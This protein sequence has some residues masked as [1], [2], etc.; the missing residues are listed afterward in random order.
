MPKADIAIVTVIPEEY[1]AVIS[2]LG[3]EGCE[4]RH[5]P[6]SAKQPNQYGWVTGEL[7][8][9][10]GRPYLVVV[11]AAISPGPT[12]M[13]NAIAAT[14]ARFRPRHVLLVG[15]AGGFPLDG[16]GRG[17]VAISSVIYDYEYGKVADEFHPRHDFTYQ[18]DGA[19]LRS[20]VTLHA[21]D[22]EW[23]DL[24]G[25][26]R[27]EAAGRPKLLPG[28]IASG[29][30]VVDNA[31]NAFFAS[32][33]ASW[34]KILAV[35][36]EGAGA[37][38]TVNTAISGG[39]QVGFLMIR[40]IS[41]MPKGGVGGEPLP[42]TGS[43]EGN[44]AERDTWKKYA[45]A[46]AANFTVHWIKRGWPVP[47]AR[48]A[49]R[50]PATKP[51]A[52]DG[53]PP[54][55]TAIARVDANAVEFDPFAT[56][57]DSSVWLGFLRSLAPGGDGSPGAS[58]G[59]SPAWG[60]VLRAITERLD[61]AA[62]PASTV[63]TELELIKTHLDRHET[64]VAE[65]KLKELESRSADRLTPLQWYQLKA[66]RSRI[67]SGRWQWEQAG[68]ELLD[69]KRH[70]PTAE[71]ARINEAL[72]YEL[73]GEREKAHELATALRAEF[74]HS[75][76]LLT[77]W[78]RT[79]PASMTFDTLAAAA[80]SSVKEDEELNLA[81]AHRAFL[82][83]RFSEAI[84]FAQRATELDPASPHAWFLLG[85][86]KHATGFNL[87]KD[88]YTPLLREAAEHYDRAV[89]L[90]QAE[91]LSGLEAAIRFNRGKV[92]HLLGD[93]RAEADYQRAV[94]LARPDQR[95]RTE[96]AGF[97]VQVGRPTDALR[98]LEAETGEPKGERLFFEAAARY[99]RNIGD[100]RLRA[101][102]LLEA[103]VAEE[104]SDRWDDAHVL[105]VQWAVEGKG[106][107]AAR[108]VITGSRLE[109][110]NPLV[111][112]T[113]SGWLS[114]SEGHK[115]VARAA[116]HKA[117]DV[118]TAAARRD[119]IFLLAQALVSVDDD[120]LALPLLERCYRPGVLNY[121]CKKLL[122][123]ARRLERHDVSSRVCR[124]LR[125]AGS[126]DPRA[127]ET[128]IGILQM[129]DPNEAL[130][131]ARDHLVRHP[132]DR[133]VA[134][135][136]SALAL[137]LDRSELIIADLS[138]LPA[139]SDLT[140]Q[141][142]GMVVG[143][144]A[145]TGQHAAAL[146]YAYDALRAHFESEFAHGQYLAYFFKLNEHC[147]DLRVGGR[148]EPG[149]AVCYREERDETD[150]WAV[151]EDG[152]KPDLARDEYAPDHPLSKALSGHSVGDTV[153]LSH[154]GLQPRSAV[155]RQAFS[156]FI[157]R[158]H[159]C[160]DRYQLRFPG[161]TA[162]QM[163][164]VGS[165][166]EFDPS[167]IIQSL[168]QR[169]QHIERLDRT[170]R[171][172]PM[173]FSMYVELAGR[174]EIDA[175]AHMASN[176]DL[177]IRCGS[178]DDREL[179]AAIDLVKRC[180][181]LVLDLTALITLARLDLLRLVGGGSRKWV[182][183]R[184]MYERVLHLHE[185]ADEDRGSAGSVVLTDG[186]E[187]ARVEITT[188][189]R[190]RRAEFLA[191]MRNAIQDRCDIQPCPQAAALDPT[192]REQLVQAIG[193][194]SLDSILLAAHP[195]AVLWTDDLVLG[196]IGRTDF[197]TSRV[198]TQAVLFVLR[199]EGTISQQEFDQA[200][201]KLVGWHYQ[202]VVLN[203]ETLI[204]AAEVAEWRMDHWPVPPVM[205]TLANTAAD[206]IMRLRIA[207]Q[208]IRLTWR[209]DAPYH[210]RQS[211]LFAVLAGLNS[212]RLVRRLHQAVPLVFSVDVL[213]ADEVRDCIAV[214]LRHPT[215]LVLP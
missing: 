12:Q 47:P 68:R 59:G 147:P 137:R 85:E 145:E 32:V 94:E 109:A 91:K 195:D 62:P 67:F 13:A 213:S 184:T 150:R 82:E 212:V 33:H 54:P 69:A 100:D 198:W 159:D 15:I 134:L 151:I 61:G 31:D 30:K 124:E 138:R 37:V 36:M 83:S 6:G 144:L 119:H 139:V 95:M 161:G 113:L 185:Q 27:P 175:W 120:A 46:V 101:Q 186:G 129:Y 123:T 86:A 41:D 189:Q 2:R 65:T 78:I 135:W 14:L 166:D 28:V 44:K 80:A 111:F 89:T 92:R 131:V 48:R 105:I 81:L 202:G 160:R 190:E 205:R 99:E 128:E 169:K 8:D 18:I 133:H 156:K 155:I 23:A 191:S 209:R 118:L 148:A 115:D 75:V 5:D 26:L 66:L 136:Q 142:S 43:P 178:G 201:A 29:S 117:L 141:G 127:I 170:Y 149:A 116:F 79:A 121:E 70:T 60:A 181:T 193:R 143:I 214:W 53:D 24:D 49:G 102:A 176:P 165:G 57:A 52:D 11:A 90:A 63:D 168:E 211:F 180:K 58:R 16:Q 51:P 98:E 56:T 208:A 167:P 206:P 197:Q 203:E 1:S 84:P 10:I 77:I 17:D 93:S 22:S 174:N 192:R 132:G 55:S 7:T 88:S 40:G 204:A 114:A 154:S 130:R 39:Q 207:A 152:P 74:T 97:L 172:E 87:V 126:A 4:V 162:I 108:R 196:L 107:E 215:G 182:A 183:A 199:Q 9:Q 96:Y 163:I 73:L 35:E 38:A 112:W 72:G 64:E 50:A 177:G 157:H 122:D 173:P 76:R 45:A 171:N 188:E 200:V 42:T 34:P 104:A 19:L 125:E 194:Q 106:Q 153:V 164:H 187:L 110:V 21:R 3:Q 20:A 179:R 146:R 158:F 140:P 103:L 210:A 71:R 25:H